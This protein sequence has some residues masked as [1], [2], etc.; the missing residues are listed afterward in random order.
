MGTKDTFCW[1]TTSAS[2]TLVFLESV[3]TIKTNVWYHV[4]GVRGSNYLQLYVNGKLEAQTNISFPQNYGN[5]PLYFGTSGQPYYDCKLGGLLDEVSLYDR[6]LTSNEIAAIYAAGSTG[7]CRA[8]AASFTLLNL[9]TN[10]AVYGASVA[11]T[12]TVTGS[13]VTPTGTVTLMDGTN[14][15]GTGSL[16]AS[17]MAAFNTNKISVAGSPYSIEAIYNGDA[18]YASSTSSPV[19]LTIAAATVTPSVTVSNKTYDGTTNG[20]I[21]GRSLSGVV[22]GDDVNLGTSGLAS[23]DDKNVGAGKTVT[24]TGLALS[25]T[26][27]VNYQLSSTSTSTSANITAQPLIVTAVADTKPYDGTTNAAAVP[28]ITSGSLHSTD[29]VD[30]VETYDTKDVGTNKTLTPAGTVNDGNG[31]NNYSYAFV[32]SANGTITAYP[33]EV[34][35]VANTKPYDGTTGALAL[36]VITSGSL[37]STD[38]ANFFEAYDTKDVGT[39]KTLTPDGIVNDGN[40]GNNYQATFVSTNIGVIS[41]VTLTVTADN[42][43]R[44][45]GA[46]NPILTAQLSGFV[47]GDTTNVLIG[48]PNLSTLAAPDSPP[49]S[50]PIIA[51]VGTL[52]ATN[53]T[54]AFV[55]GT[56]TVLAL[57]QLTADSTSGNYFVF[58]FPTVSN[59]NYQVEYNTNL[60]LG[61]WLPF[62]SVITGNDA[63]VSVTN[64]MIDPQEFF[65]LNLQP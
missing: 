43:T 59:Q 15:L 13:V 29:S 38:T 5:L 63:F 30:F 19:S 46:A 16:N 52:S 36:P 14:A 42:K 61:S 34:T 1:E 21:S 60:V 48:S 7:K 57:P 31:G 40:S 9:S 4:A 24:V 23:F 25:G 64:G 50:Y 44:W 26:T 58:S 65:R 20:T 27:S 10:L 45:F 55:N 18:N 11:F 41:P 37:Q 54:F 17:G 35:A 22:N 56:L 32:S 12:S 39:N 33:L 3:T 28:M 47:G 51:S 6:A 62:G 53:Y 49:A 2:G 8:L